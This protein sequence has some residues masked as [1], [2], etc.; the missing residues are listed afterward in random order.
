MA[1][2]HAGAEQDGGILS[3][4][5]YQLRRLLQAC[6][7]TGAM[8][9]HTHGRPLR[10]YSDLTSFP[11]KDSLLHNSSGTR[12]IGKLVRQNSGLMWGQEFCLY[13]CTGGDRT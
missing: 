7:P 8:R 2:Q 1:L 6:H 9:Q 12:E 4:W 11:I 3:L 5:Y 10:V 13:A